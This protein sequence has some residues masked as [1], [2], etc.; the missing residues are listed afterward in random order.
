MGHIAPLLTGEM[1]WNHGWDTAGKFRNLEAKKN[2]PAKQ[3]KRVQ[4]FQEV[5]YRYRT[6]STVG[7]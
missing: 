6:K 2:Y 7:I 1:N 3:H 4:I 5:R